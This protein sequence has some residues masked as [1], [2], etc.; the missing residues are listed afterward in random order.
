MTKEQEKFITNFRIS[1][2]KKVL[3]KEFSNTKWVERYFV[4]GNEKGCTVI[5]EHYE[6]DF[7]NDEPFE[8]TH[9]KKWKPIIKTKEI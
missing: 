6:K 7:E 8:V 5:A 9:Y 2:K 1:D 3:I 4:I